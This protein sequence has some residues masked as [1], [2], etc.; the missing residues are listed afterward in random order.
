MTRMITKITNNLFI[1]EFSD[2]VDDESL[3]LMDKWIHEKHYC[4]QQPELPV[5]QRLKELGIT[6]IMNVM[7]RSDEREEKLLRF[8]WYNGVRVRYKFEPVP[9]DGY[10]DENMGIDKLKEGLAFAYYELDSI[11]FADYQEKVLVHCTGGIDRS[12]FVVASYLYKKI[13]YLWE[14]EKGITYG[15]NGQNTSYQFNS[16]HDAYDFI[17]KKRPFVLEHPEWIWWIE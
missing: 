9:S 15:L 14:D 6:T 1:G 16:L 13:K 12:P 17:K 2:I 3:A 5:M 11:F 8:I 10:I 4:G 7:E